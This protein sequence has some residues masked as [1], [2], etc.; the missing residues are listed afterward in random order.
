MKETWDNSQNNNKLDIAVIGMSGVFPQAADIDE[1]WENISKGKESI[2]FLSKEN[3]KEKGVP[4]EI[5]NHP[6]YVNAA[7]IISNSENFDAEFFGINPNEATAMDP[8]HRIFLECCWTLFENSGYDPEQFDGSISVFAGLAM[9]TYIQIIGRNRNFMDTISNEQLMIGNDKDFL[10]TLVSYKLNL[11]GPSVNVN[12]ACSTSLVAIHLA[13]Q[14][15]LLG[16]SDMAVAGGVSILPANSSGYLYKEQGM[17][18]PDGHCRAFD[19]Q[20]RGTIWGDGAGVVLLKRLKNAIDD[21]DHIYAIIKGSAINND[22]SL[23][24]GFTAPSIEGQSQVICEALA[25]SGLSAEQIN[26]VETHG[27]GTELGD[28]I[29]IAALTQAFREST[30]KRR[31]CPIGSVKT[32]IGHL[33]AA[34]GIAGFIKTVLALQHKKLPPH[35]HFQTPNPK[36]DFNNSPF[37][38]NS[39]LAEWQN[40]N[41]PLRAGISS[42]GLGGTNAHVIVED[43]SLF[44]KNTLQPVHMEGDALLILS[45]RSLQALDSMTDN[46][47][48][49]LEHNENLS[50]RDVSYTLACGRRSFLHRR[51]LRCKSIKEAVKILKERNPGFLFDDNSFLKNEQLIKDNTIDNQLLISWLKGKNVDWSSMFR[52]PLPFRVPLP[53]Y[54]FERKRFWVDPLPEK[55]NS[56]TTDDES[57]FFKKKDE[58][59]DWFYL[60][61][62]KPSPLGINAKIKTSKIRMIFIDKYQ[63]GESIAHQLSIHGD[64]VI[65]IVI[66]KNFVR[67]DE[68][69]FELNPADFKGYDTLLKELKN[70]GLWPDSIIYLWGIEV[71]DTQYHPDDFNSL[72][73]SQNNGFFNIL[74]L[75][76]SINKQIADKKIEYIVFT[77]NVF[78]VVGTEDICAPGSTLLGFCMVLNQEY[79]NVNCRVIDIPFSK[80]ET[81]NDNNFI[82]ALISEIQNKTPQ[83]V[84]A[85]RNNKRFVRYYDPLRVESDAPRFRTIKKNGNYLVYSGLEGIGFL[86]SQHLQKQGAKLIILEEEDF[87]QEILWDQWISEHGNNDPMSKRIIN[88]IQFKKEGAEYIG[89]ITDQPGKNPLIKALANIEK[90]LGKI[91]G[92]IHAPGASNAKRVMPMSDVTPLIWQ[93]HFK[94]VFYSM[95]VIDKLFKNK[96]LDFKIMLNSLGSVLGGTGFINITT[97]SN[98]VKAYAYKQ[99]CLGEQPW[100]IQCWDSWIIEWGQVKE[101]MPASVFNRVVPSILTDQEGIQCFEHSFSI[102]DA[103]EYVIS[104]TNLTDR[105]RRWIINLNSSQESNF[106]QKQRRPDLTEK[107]IAPQ[108]QIEKDLEK[109]FSDLL[110]ITNIGINDDFYEIGGH[111]LLGISLVNE[112]RKK[113]SIETTLY[114]FMQGRTIKA[115]AQYIIKSKA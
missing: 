54:C 90:K 2:Q 115:L 37:Y 89:S 105:Y 59:A 83:P 76:K 30:D 93:E 31:F 109:I 21:R 46:L 102:K 51:A 14:S 34:S 67:H 95:I 5:L 113:F 43:A 41:G 7:S 98:Y 1:F 97:V 78:E 18:S 29:E 3:L 15:L 19:A 23:K 13:R 86:I 79:N 82:D 32:N 70:K 50:L 55:D 4:S 74:D 52:E 53:T 71:V 80:V 92:I 111:S 8:Q 94:T 9:N 11:K 39:E 38:V 64:T 68:S 114:S 101:L 66:G 25:V 17:Q 96:M 107:Y 100:T 35:L 36:I 87:P 62:W 28:P 103:I 63:L 99:K 106:T 20:A 112:L 26:Y 81:L 91:D 49:Y 10:N 16:E 65:K 6:N 45:A 60:P 24:V 56:G 85:Y 75:S 12:T 84:C 104:A 42:L 58:M 33:N 27:T 72:V 110:G 57:K 47:A 61:L 73:M 44:K 77:N 108:T 69:N 48:R 22:G 88:A 40:G